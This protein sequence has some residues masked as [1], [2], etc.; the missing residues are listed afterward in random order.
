MRIRFIL[1]LLLSFATC[2]YTLAAGLPEPIKIAPH[3][4]AWIGPYGPPSRENQGFRMNL[5]F[6]VGDDAVAVIDSGYGDGMAVT[7]LEKIRHVTD[8]PVSYVINTN[9]QPHRILGNAAFRKNGATVIASEAASSRMVQEGVAM[10]SSAENILGLAPGNVHAPGPPD[11]GLQKTSEISLG[12]ITLQIIPV[13]T[14]HTAGSL[15][16]EVVEDKVI[17]AGDVLYRGR[18]LAILPVSRVDGWISAFDT[19]RKYQDAL[20]VPGHGEPGPLSDFEHSTYKYL[21]TLKAH[22]DDTIDQG[23][24]LQEAIDSLDQSSWKDL[25][26]FDALSGRNAHQTYLE[27]EAAA[28]E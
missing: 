13:S 11:R 19:L 25:V 26:D 2:R 9:S 22:M 20:F 14:A 12:G 3:S 17:Y 21:T 10:A 4:Y 24:E 18:L 28:F 5:G 7:M 8:R 15:V 1:L 16:V 6:V 27:R 23:M